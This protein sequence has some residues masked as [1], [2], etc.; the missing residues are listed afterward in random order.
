MKP[1]KQRRYL[2][3][4]LVFSLLAWIACSFGLMLLWHLKGGPSTPTARPVTLA[5]YQALLDWNKD[6]IFHIV[7]AL[8]FSYSL[9]AMMIL[10]LLVKTKPKDET[11]GDA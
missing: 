2:I 8:T 1:F 10:D 3:C 4:L 5:E 11:S 7:P 9:I 6:M